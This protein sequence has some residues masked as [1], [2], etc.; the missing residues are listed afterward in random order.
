M[1]GGV[2]LEPFPVVF[3]RLALT[4]L[5]G[6]FIIGIGHVCMLTHFTHDRLR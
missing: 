2:D 3:D 5:Q 1:L 6:W 4:A